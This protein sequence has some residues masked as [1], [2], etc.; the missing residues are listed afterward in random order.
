MSTESIDLDKFRLRKFARRLVEIGEVEIHEEPVAMADLSAIIE[1]TPKATLFKKAGPQQYEM[2]AAV[3]GGR[4]RLAAAF[5]VEEGKIADEYTRRMSNPQRVVEIPTGEAPVQE[6][7]KTGDEIDL[8]ALPFH[9]QHEQDGA[10]YISSA[11]D[12]AVDPVTGKRNV[13]CRRLMLRDRTTMRSNLSQPSDLKKIYLEALGRGERLPVSFAVGSHPI[14][15]LAA[16]HRYTGDEFGL[17]ATLRGESV[18]MV[19]GISNGVL[20][21]ADAEMIIEGYFD[22]L[23][24]REKEGPYGEFWGFYGPVHMDP[25]FHVTAITM[26]KD[27]LFQTVVHGGRQIGRMDSTNLSCIMT[28]AALWRTLR[29]VNIEPA[30]V[31]CVPSAA[32]R[33][34]IRIALK[35]GGAAGQARAAISAAFSVI[36]VRNVTI[37]DDDIDVT[38]AEEVDWAMSARYRADRDTVIANGFPAFYMDPTAD[39]EATVAK[40]G[41]D[42]TAPK[43]LPDTLVNR[44]PLPPRLALAPRFQT[45]RQALESG[46]MYFMQIM[47]ALGSDDGRE[48]A[49]EL[50]TLREEGVLVRNDDGQWALGSGGDLPGGMH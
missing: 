14:D 9:L 43:G 44:R 37:V 21:P 26:R 6:V 41:F 28:E 1:A 25:V 16:S 17:I 46:P 8:A 39:G 24:Y 38:N 15:F 3:A 29:A 30:A 19:R 11:I 45:V 49:L 36:Y 13:G 42:A 33:T 32:S 12:Y 22:E 7:V 2:I 20:A 18:P 31:Y 5:G 40:V 47:E 34:A 50:A 48:I 35:R 4:R 10:P 27:V 23:G